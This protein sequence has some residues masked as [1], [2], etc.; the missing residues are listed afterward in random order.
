MP[1][2]KPSEMPPLKKSIQFYVRPWSIKRLFLWV[3]QVCLFLRIKLF[4][5][6][7]YYISNVFYYRGFYALSD[8]PRFDLSF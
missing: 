7:F 4:D 6:Y 2:M 3:Y 8:I 1:Q 5:Y